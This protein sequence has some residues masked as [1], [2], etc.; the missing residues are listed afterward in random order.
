MVSASLGNSVYA[1]NLMWI[2][3]GMGAVA[4][5]VL[6]PYFGDVSNIIFSTE[7]SEDLDMRIV[8]YVSLIGGFLLLAAL[9]LNIIQR[10][11]SDNS[12][13]NQKLDWFWRFLVPGMVRLESKL[14]RAASYKINLMVRNAC[15]VHKT[16]EFDGRSSRG[17]GETVGNAMLAFVRSSDRTEDLLGGVIETWKRIFSGSLFEEDGIWF[18]THLL[19]GNLA[20]SILVLAVGAIFYVLYESDWFQQLLTTLD[21]LGSSLR[22]RLTLPLFLGIACSELAVFLITANYIPSTVSTILQYRS[23]GIGSLHSNRFQRLRLAVDQSTLVFPAMFWGTLYTSTAIG[24]FVMMVSGLLFWPDFA[25]IAIFIVAS[26][27]GIIITML[28]KWIALVGYRRY[29]QSGYY[30]KSV[31]LAN[32]LGLILE[33]WVSDYLLSSI[34][35]T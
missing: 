21:G 10:G 2:V 27:S 33:S 23:G 8:Y 17:E 6:L 30:R 15:E 35:R 18:S 3:V 26:L 14:K 31:A 13:T 12:S 9:V 24:F 28:V 25:E 7:K 29:N 32:L 1:T 16:A 11:Y 19:A 4:C 20:Q 5:F 34:W 22:W